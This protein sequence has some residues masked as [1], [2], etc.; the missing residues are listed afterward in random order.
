MHTWYGINIYT[1]LHVD[2]RPTPQ[3]VCNLEV[4][5]SHTTPKRWNIFIFIFKC[6]YSH[7]N[8]KKD[9]FT[10]WMVAPHFNWFVTWK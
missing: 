1:Y 4:K 7:Y 5:G 6:I 2:D 10:T 3:L 9:G 8:N